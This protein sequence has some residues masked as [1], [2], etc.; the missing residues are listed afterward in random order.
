MSLKDNGEFEKIAK[1]LGS[2]YAATMYIAAE[3]RRR[4]SSLKYSILDSQAISWVV[5]GVAP[6]PPSNMLSDK[7]PD[8]N[9]RN[10]IISTMLDMVIDSEV[11]ECVSSSI[12]LSVSA[13]INKR[14]TFHNDTAFPDAISETF[15]CDFISNNKLPESNIVFDYGYITDEPRKSRVRVLT[16]M[17]WD[18]IK[19]D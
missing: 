18:S 17:V 2:P 9:N 8:E 11:R 14:T 10:S 7:E 6:E 1:Q 12:K 5:S 15:A 13:F 19:H 3:S 4:S 16:R